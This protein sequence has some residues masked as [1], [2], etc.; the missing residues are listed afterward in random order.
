L[1]VV[2]DLVKERTVALKTNSS[3]RGIKPYEPGKP[4]EELEREYRIT[5]AVKLASNENPL[6][7]SPA[8]YKA[9]QDHLH[10]MNRY[11]DPRCYELTSMLAGKFRVDP[12]NIVVGNGSDDI[13]SLL[14]AAFLDSESEALMPAPSFLMYEICVRTARGIPVMVPLRDFSI[15]FEKMAARITG[16]TRMIFLTNP[17]NPTGS[18][19]TAEAFAAFLE[20]V[21]PDV[22][23]VVDEAYIEFARQPDI[24]NS[25]SHPLSDRR[26]IALRTFSKAYGLAGFRIGYGIMDKEVAELLHRIR[27]PFNVNSP[28]QAAGMAAL[29]D[30]AFLRKT[31]KTVH[32]G[33]DYLTDELGR[34]GIS[35]LPTQSNFL[36][37]DVKTD[38]AAVFQSLLASGV[39]VKSMKSYGFN[40]YI[41]VNAGTGE[42]NR[43]FMAALKGVLG[44][45][46]D[47]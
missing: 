33:I 44:K 27:Q 12:E 8:V 20:K 11:P 45:Q 39:I 2:V 10:K 25:L 1:R 36:M 4:I 13:I 42:E 28:A 3:I 18:A 6:G 47:A 40:T 7:C 43:R 26:V 5:D 24:F 46:R 29:Q 19:F 9:V 41:R 30:D 37:I 23:V 22:L 31:L 21:P 17:F 32:N 35:C 14:T 15:D 16:K 34:S 38:A